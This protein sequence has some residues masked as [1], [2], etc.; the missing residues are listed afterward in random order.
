MKRKPSWLKVKLPQKE[1]YGKIKKILK[2]NKLHTVCIEARCPNLGQCWDQGTATF[3]ILGD[4]CTRACRFCATKSGDPRGII[5]KSEP[6][7]LRNAVKMMGLDYVVI[8]SVDRDDLKDGGAGI[9]RETVRLL[10]EYRNDIGIEVLVPDFSGEYKLIESVVNSGIN[11]FA[12]NIEVVRRI[13]DSVRDRRASYDLSLNVLN[14]A[15]EIN[16]DIIIKSG[17]MV[18]IGETDEEVFKVMEDAANNNVKLFTIGQ[19]LQPTRKNVDVDR[20]VVP[21][22]FSLYEKEGRK[23]GLIVKSGPL[24][25]SSYM[26]KTTYLE[27]IDA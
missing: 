20:F 12:H 19:Y 26:A 2:D 3:M 21:E 25:R 10:K 18:G 16:K 27:A 11:V 4:V 6:E 7:R 9:F 8:T 13:S 23:I 5:D 24:V 15:S 14:L 1:Q 22:T 17:I